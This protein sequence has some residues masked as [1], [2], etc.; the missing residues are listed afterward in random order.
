MNRTHLPYGVYRMRLI[1]P[2]AA[3]DAMGAESV[4]VSGTSLDNLIYDASE[5]IARLANPSWPAADPDGSCY[6]RLPDS[7]CPL[8]FAEPELS[9]NE[10]RNPDGTQQ[11]FVGVYEVGQNY[12]GPEEGGWWYSTGELVQQTAVAS[13]D[14]AEELR[15][16]LSET[17]PVKGRYGDPDY[18]IS[19]D[20]KPLVASFPEERPRYE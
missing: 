7:W 3:L 9:A 1:G 18:Q 17:F 20:L 2:D 12:G 8:E 6:D 15:E 19:I 5:A 14:E 10:W 4:L 13:R 11:W 16:T